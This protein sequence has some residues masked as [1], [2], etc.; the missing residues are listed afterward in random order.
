M[1]NEAALKR[2]KARP[3]TTPA[4]VQLQPSGRG[5]FSVL[6]ISPAII[7]EKVRALKVEMAME[8]A[9]VSANW[10]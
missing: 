3:T 9:I 1:P 6:R 5:G 2:P 8:K 10:R 4:T 7:G